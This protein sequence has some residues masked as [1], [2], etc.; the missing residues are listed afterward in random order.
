MKR[1]KKKKLEKIKNLWKPATDGKMPAQVLVQ[2]AGQQQVQEQWLEAQELAAQ[3]RKQQQMPL[4]AN[5]SRK[6]LFC[7]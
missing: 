6:H 2:S 4:K 7:T 3:L 5:T 1:Y